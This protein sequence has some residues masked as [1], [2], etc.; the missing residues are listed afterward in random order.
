M[1]TGFLLNVYRHYYQQSN[2]KKLLEK[3]RILRT[4]Q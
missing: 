3:E 1:F 4:I 2:N